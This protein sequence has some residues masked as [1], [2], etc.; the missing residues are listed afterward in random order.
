MNHNTLKAITDV[1]KACEPALKREVDVIL[2]E[3]IGGWQVELNQQ[4]SMADLAAAFNCPIIMVIG[5]RLGCMNHA[6]LTAESIL[7]KGLRLQGWIANQIDPDF[8][9]NFVVNWGFN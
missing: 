8:E 4:E 6:L 7:A 1:L 5:M 9:H 3:G 2:I